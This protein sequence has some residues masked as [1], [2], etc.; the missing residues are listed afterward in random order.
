MHNPRKKIDLGQCS[1]N[2]QVKV[3]SRSQPTRFPH[4]NF[5][6]A[7]IHQG[8]NP[9]MQ[10]HLGKQPSLGQ[11]QRRRDPIEQPRQPLRHGKA[12]MDA[13]GEGMISNF[14]PTCHYC[15]I[16]GHIRPNC[17]HYIKLCRAKSM[18]E[19]KKA[20]ARLHVHGKDE[21]HLHDP[22]TPR[23]LDH[24]TTRIENLSP[25]WTKNN[26]PT[27]YETNKSHKGSIKSNGLGRSIGP[28]D[29]R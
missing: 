28:H 17:F 6:Q 13:Q 11:Q 26:E 15:G 3:A 23:T 1:Q 29:L 8:K 27:C 22:M 5:P 14:N 18:I 21:N 25:K 16:D 19:K 20:R 24:L 9:I 7:Q 10:A 2:A 4:T 12:P